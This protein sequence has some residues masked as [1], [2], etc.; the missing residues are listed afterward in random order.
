MFVLNEVIVGAIVLFQ[1][2]YT[3]CFG[4]LTRSPHLDEIEGE[5]FGVSE[6]EVKKLQQE[7]AESRQHTAHLIKQSGV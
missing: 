6:E 4:K 7:L 3:L 5:G 2:I 1:L